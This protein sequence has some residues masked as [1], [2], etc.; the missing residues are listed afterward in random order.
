M[1]SVSYANVDISY[2]SHFTICSDIKQN[3]DVG[4]YLVLRG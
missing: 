2:G 1:T 4:W 3:T